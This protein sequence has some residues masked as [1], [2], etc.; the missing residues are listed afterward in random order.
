MYVEIDV[1]PAVD[2]TP[3]CL[4][5]SISRSIRL[6]SLSVWKL[7]LLPTTTTDLFL[8]TAGSFNL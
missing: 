5:L 7:K 8:S 1:A 4:F 3:L 6:L 2:W